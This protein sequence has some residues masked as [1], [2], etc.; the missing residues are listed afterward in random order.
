MEFSIHGSPVQKQAHGLLKT[1]VMK[2]NVFPFGF[3]VGGNFSSS[4]KAPQELVHSGHL[5]LQWGWVYEG[6]DW[7]SNQLQNQKWAIVFSPP[8]LLPPPLSFP[9]STLVLLSRGKRAPMM[10][11]PEAVSMVGHSV[12]HHAVNVQT[13]PAAGF[14]FNVNSFCSQWGSFWYSYAIL[15]SFFYCKKKINPLFSTEKGF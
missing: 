14:L 11:V 10:W 4:I 5:C 12:L 3:L 15:L 7:L 6:L 9:P 1:C 8:L 13:Q 2:T